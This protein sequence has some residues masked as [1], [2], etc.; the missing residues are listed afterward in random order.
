MHIISTLTLLLVRAITL[1][2]ESASV[3]KKSSTMQAHVLAN[4]IGQVLEHYTDAHRIK[5]TN[6]LKT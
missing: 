6:S 3:L 2:F 4:T 1:T 5:N